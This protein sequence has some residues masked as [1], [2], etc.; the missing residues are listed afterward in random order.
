M[1]HP[2]DI[3]PE[4]MASCLGSS[5]F[6]V[7]IDGAWR[8]IPGTQ[9]DHLDPATPARVH[10]RR[11]ATEVLRCHSVLDLGAA[12]DAVNAALMPWG[13][14]A[15]GLEATGTAR[16]SVSPR[17]RELAEES[18]RRLR[19]L[20]LEHEAEMHRLRHLQDILS[21]PDLLRVWWMSRFPDR[22]EQLEQLT[23]ALEHL[24]PPGQ[25]P[26]GHRT[27]LRQFADQLIDVLHN[28]AQQQLLLQAVIHAFRALGH[29]D[30]ADTAARWLGPPEQENTP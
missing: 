20:D 11:Q 13:R 9:P 7:R 8:A 17:D 18:A 4:P 15:P 26:A 25:Q 5:C 30:L 28:P 29:T 12:Q 23:S 10:L 16:L 14:P 27:E 19:A 3:G 1:G 24:A 22:P 21:D 2:F 6:T